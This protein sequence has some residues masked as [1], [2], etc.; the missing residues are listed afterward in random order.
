MKYIGAH[1]KTVGGVQEAPVNAY[2]IGAKAFALFVKN[3]MQWKA[4]PF[5]EK[6]IKDFKENLEKYG[7]SVKKI[8]PHDGYLIN[9]GSPDK[10]KREKSIE[11][12]LEE[13]KKCEQLGLI[14]LNFHPGSHLGKISEEECIENIINA[15]N[16]A[17][18]ETEF[19]TFVVENTAGQGSNVGYKF[20]HIR[21]IINGIIDKNRIGVCLDTCHTYA[22]GYDITTKYK[23]EETIN[24]FDKIVG[25]NY[26]KAFHI[27]DSKKGLGSRVDRHENLGKGIMGMEPFKFIMNDKRFEEMLFILETIDDTLW[28]EEIKLLY[29]LID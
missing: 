5:S 19:I 21:D 18:K 26:L 7:Y 28:E 16:F 20:E 15:L 23:Y 10:E 22:S 14:Y 13:A 2:K 1:V 11:S 17:I 24:L 3:Q 9:L 4:L 27:N 8:L 29:S 25:L 12:F 6:T